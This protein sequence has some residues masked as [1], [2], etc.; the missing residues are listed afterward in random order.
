[1]M[2]QSRFVDVV[3][4]D[5]AVNDLA[6]VDKD[7]VFVDDLADMSDVVGYNQDLLRVMKQH[8]L[9]YDS[10]EEKEVSD[11]LLFAR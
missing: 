11:Y 4:S 8:G 1:M 9:F 6:I 2:V 5:R 3:L 7:N 10:F